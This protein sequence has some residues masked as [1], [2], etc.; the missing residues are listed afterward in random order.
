[1]AVPVVA[2]EGRA[3]PALLKAENPM[4]IPAVRYE[5]VAPEI[6]RLTLNRAEV[7]NA[8]DT[9][10]LYELNDAFDKAAQDDAVKVI[11]LRGEGP[12]FSS[13]H[14]L[15]EPQ[16]K[17]QIKQFRTVGTWCGFQCAGAEALMA[18]EKEIYIG[19]SER[20]RNIPKPTIAAKITI[21]SCMAKNAALDSEVRSSLRR[22]FS[23]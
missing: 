2:R 16:S 3:R 21:A 5:N 8:Q 1:M 19:F 14:D 9:R 22:L 18:R 17:E 6:A 15:R 7:R 12:H 10:L 4:G 13:G 11:I 20:W 23:R